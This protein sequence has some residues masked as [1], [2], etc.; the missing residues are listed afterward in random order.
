MKQFRMI[1]VMLL[2]LAGLSFA[3]CIGEPVQTQSTLSTDTSVPELTK[4]T[5]LFST[6]SAT[7]DVSITEPAAEEPPVYEIL[8]NDAGE[9]TGVRFTLEGSDTYTWE[10]PV[11]SKLPMLVDINAQLTGFIEYYIGEDE[12]RFD[13]IDLNEKSILYRHKNQ[14]LL[15]YTVGSVRYSSTMHGCEPS[16]H[17]NIEAEHKQGTFSVCSVDPEIGLP[18]IRIAYYYDLS[19][20][21]P[22]AAETPP[23]L[24]VQNAEKTPTYTFLQNT[25]GEYTGARFVLADGSTYIWESPAPLTLPPAVHLSGQRAACVIEYAAEDGERR[26]DWVDLNQKSILYRHE[27]QRY[28][29]YT[30]GSAE[31]VSDDFLQARA[32]DSKEYFT[33]CRENSENGD[34]QLCIT[35][36]HN[37]IS[38]AAAMK[39]S[40]IPVR[41]VLPALGTQTVPVEWKYKTVV[42]RYPTAWYMNEDGNVYGRSD[43]DPETGESGEWKEYLCFEGL[44][45]LY[46]S[47]TPI[48]EAMV[49]QILDFKECF[50]KNG[51]IC[52]FNDDYEPSV[53]VVLDEHY[54]MKI[55]TYNHWF[56]SKESDLFYSAHM[57]WPTIENLFF[58]ENAR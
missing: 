20:G 10:C 39:N 14:L 3:S 12:W 6:E 23:D 43:I 25:A 55:N 41:R 38:L 47:E 51:Y 29:S 19:T 16:G 27:N 22:D 21:V 24:P 42:T 36:Y 1:A 17:V 32:N 48:D 8:Q 35:Y 58:P 54:Y 57:L 18:Q 30:G 50:T 52:Y 26:F 33:V 56:L 46:Y 13:W 4:E 28:I 9:Y 11:R 40:C 2:I 7:T 31:I 37:F 45:T 5:S 53:V 34:P 44:D 15:P 49:K